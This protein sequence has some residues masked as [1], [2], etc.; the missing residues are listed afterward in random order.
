[1]RVLSCYSPHLLQRCILK[2]QQQKVSSCD[3]HM[4]TQLDV[5]NLDEKGDE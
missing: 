2:G 4:L 1:M 5:N 3:M